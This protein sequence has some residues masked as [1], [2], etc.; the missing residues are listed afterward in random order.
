MSF[1]FKAPIRWIYTGVTPQ[2]HTWKSCCWVLVGGLVKW[3]AGLRWWLWAAGGFRSWETRARFQVVKTGHSS[4]AAWSQVELP[5]QWTSSL[6]MVLLILLHFLFVLHPH[7]PTFFCTP[8]NDKYTPFTCSESNGIKPRNAIQSAITLLKWMMLK[9]SSISPNI[10][11]T[12]GHWHC[13]YLLIHLP[14]CPVASHYLALLIHQPFFN[15]Y[16]G[17]DQLHGRN[18]QLN[19]VLSLSSLCIFIII[20]FICS[21]ILP[22]VEQITVQLFPLS[23]CPFWCGASNYCRQSH[24]LFMEPVG[25]HS[26]NL[27][28]QPLFH[29]HMHLA[30]LFSHTRAGRHSKACKLVCWGV[31]SDNDSVPN[32]HGHIF[33]RLAKPPKRRRSFV[34]YLPA[35]TTTFSECASACQFCQ[36]RLPGEMNVEMNGRRH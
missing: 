18:T 7:V 27:F 13:M 11:L 23:P 15:L 10:V 8:M 9:L 35:T 3:V 14:H 12:M 34:P 28:S 5:R 26:I 2:Q 19:I 4:I 32:S 16:F 20:I 1:C 17:R 22:L 31:W 21:E 6:L 24:K 25:L 29:T 33:S 36:L 30:R